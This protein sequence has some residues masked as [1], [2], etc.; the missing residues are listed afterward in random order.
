MDALQPAAV[1]ETASD[2]Q[3]LE[4]TQ[5]ASQAELPDREPEGDAAPGP[6]EAPEAPEASAAE[7]DAPAAAE[8]AAPVVPPAAPPPPAPSE[9]PG[10][11]AS[12]SS[13]PAGDPTKPPVPERVGPPV[14]AYA[15]TA[16]RT[17]RVAK[18]GG[19]PAASDGKPALSNQFETPSG[20][21][22]FLKTGNP[23]P[24]REDM[25]QE[26]GG[27]PT[28]ITEPVAKPT[29]PATLLVGGLAVIGLCCMAALAL[30]V[31]LLFG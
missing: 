14:D 21:D 22:W 20:A 9:T 18:G 24:A 7:A 1:S 4:N 27:D 12:F 10:P 28:L 26:L 16:D 29:S 25:G 11:P 30:L 17:D 15:E 19:P 5:A 31:W 13:A 2:R 3:N 6:E 23:A 8:P